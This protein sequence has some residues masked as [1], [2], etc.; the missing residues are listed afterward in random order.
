M[1]IPNNSFGLELGTEGSL[2]STL[3]PSYVGSLL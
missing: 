3:I 1:N 2:E